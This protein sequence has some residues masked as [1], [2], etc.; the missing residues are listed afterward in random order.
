[1]AA[2]TKPTTCDSNNLKEFHVNKYLLSLVSIAEGGDSGRSVRE[3]RQFAR[4]ITVL[5]IL[6]SASVDG[7]SNKEKTDN[8]R[9]RNFIKRGNSKEKES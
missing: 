1:M 8:N 7:R 9:R 3:R 6:V 2:M 4:D 5:S